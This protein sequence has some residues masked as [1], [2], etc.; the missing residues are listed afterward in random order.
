MKKILMLG[1]VITDFNLMAYP[2]APAQSYQA[3]AKAMQSEMAGGVLYLRDIVKNIIPK[4]TAELLCPGDAI[5]DAGV[6]VFNTWKPFP[7][8]SKDK[9]KVWRIDR[10]I[11]RT[12][13]DKAALKRHIEEYIKDAPKADLLVIDDLCLGFMECLMAA[14]DAKKEMAGKTTPPLLK[15]LLDKTK[16]EQ[17]ILKLSSLNHLQPFIDHGD[18]V[19]VAVGAHTLRERG[20]AISEGLSW[21]K[22]IEDTVHEFSSGLSSLDLARCRRVVVLFSAE[23]A[24]VFERNGKAATVSQE[25]FLY[26]PSQYE[27]SFKASRPGKM[28]GHLSLVAAAVVR[29]LILDKQCP[30][31]FAALSLALTAIRK[32]HEDGLPENEKA[33]KQD[34]R[35][36]FNGHIKTLCEILTCTDF[37]ASPVPSDG[38]DENAKKRRQEQREQLDKKLGVFSSAFR[39][40]LLEYPSK[41]Q[42]GQSNLLGDY[43][44]Y[45]PEYVAAKA[46]Q[47]VMQGTD[48]ALSNVPVVSYGDFLTADREEIERINAIRRLIVSYLANTQ[49]KKPLSIAVFGPPGSGKSF[50]IKQLATELG[51]DKKSIH[52]FNLS[53][54][55]KDS[56]EL[57]VAFHQVRDA[58]IQGNVPL[59]FWDEFDSGNLDWLKEFLAPMQDAEFRA[60]SVIHPLG[61]AIFV[62]AGGVFS[63]FEEFEEETKEKEKSENAYK[64][65]KAPDF[66]SRLRG[67][68]NIKG[69][70]PQASGEQNSEYLIR[71]AILL[72]SVL[73]RNCGSLI[74]KK[75]QMS[76]SAPVVQA[77]LRIEKFKHGA[78]SLE[79]IITMSNLVD[80]SFFGEAALPP[81]HL[82]HLHVDAAAFREIMRKETLEMPMIEMIAE[83]C[84]TAW[85]AQKER[86]GY[87][88]GPERSDEPPKLHPLLVSYQK[89]NESDKENNRITARLTQA[90]LLEV[91]LQIERQQGQGKAPDLSLLDAHLDHLMRIEHDIWMRDHLLQGY[92]YSD[93]T[94][95]ALKLHKC[96]KKFNDLKPEDKELDKVI[97]ESLG[98]VLKKNNYGVKKI[99]AAK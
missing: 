61:K 64:G 11:G 50:S 59:I 10:F 30:S 95:D 25:K 26:H 73:K 29:H 21:D 5:K 98:D 67:Y 15:A 40:D 80:A 27:G 76:I 82:L 99:K 3:L 81:D 94:N 56:A 9:A 14:G 93:V 71:R 45:K 46:F 48:K 92:E 1:D 34:E 84:H 28:S 65:K 12:D 91:G 7:K 96:V 13:P 68:V 72:R 2:P 66:I 58:T 39:H 97:V 35:F 85:K 63:S 88:H 23:G 4:E 32:Q 52:T 74:G 44:G 69:P 89:L 75:G 79:S 62:F 53:E 33:E 38:Q 60:G 70:N 8:I 90:K 19:T 49:D 83:A 17:I 36:D 41:K 47:I 20:A 42:S 22:T 87:R 55:K 6:K 24:A 77:F 18:K 43:A 54:F 51:F 37:L 57:Q 31:L 16:P 78:R 86:E